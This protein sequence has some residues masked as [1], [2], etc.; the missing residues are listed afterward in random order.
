VLEGECIQGA[1]LE[2]EG[3]DGFVF[4]AGE[5]LSKFRAGDALLVGDGADF[6]AARQLVY[7]RYDAESGR[8]ELGP[9]RYARGREVPL[10]LGL[11]YCVDRRPLGLRGR[12]QDVVRLG[13]AQADIAGVLRGD[14]LPARDEERFAKAEKLLTDRGMNEGQVRAGADAISTGRLC[15]VQGPPGA[16]KTRLLAEVISAL[17]AA[18]CRIALT[19]FTH[20]AVDHVL[21]TL[22]KLAPELPLFKLGV[23]SARDSHVRAAGVRFMDP[24]QASRLP[25][26]GALVAGT[27]FQLAKLPPKAAFHFTVFDEAAQL[28]IPHAIAGMLLSS[29]W[30]FLGDHRQLPPVVTSHHADASVTTSIFEHLHALYGGHLLDVSYRMNDQV[31]AVIGETFY[32][33]RLTSAPGVAS[34]RMPFNA[35]GA[36]DD[37]LDPEHSAVLARV[38]H[39]QPGM[40][41]IEEANLIADLVGELLT[42]HGVGSGDIA[43]VAPFRSQVR[44]IRSALQRKATPGSDSIA[45]ETIERIQGQEREVVLVSLAVGD[46]E[47][48]HARSSFFFSGNRLNVA[49]SRARSKFVL[50]AAK[51][52]FTALPSEPRALKAASTFRRLFSRLPQVDVSSVYA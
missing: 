22:R 51:G 44:M 41:S 20:R 11:A 2:S 26:T 19:A 49:L 38:D 4:K 1:V 7:R 33:G 12:L 39:M 43:I 24:R 52:A 31:C 29:R 25:T 28:P 42:R 32:G 47:T 13:F 50:V 9:D 17:C 18:G 5:N 10:E 46:P 8:L 37:I 40:R 15:L 34:R 27:C 21:L 16:G 48:L 30:I 3:A 14:E 6:A 36:L 45:V 23:A 35:G